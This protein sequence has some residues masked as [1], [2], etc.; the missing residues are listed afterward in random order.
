MEFRCGFWYAKDA[1]KIGMGG[2][3]AFYDFYRR[4]YIFVGTRL[5]TDGS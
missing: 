1:R 5:T 3:A 4:C 2:G